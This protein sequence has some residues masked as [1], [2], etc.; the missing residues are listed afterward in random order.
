MREKRT[1]K[2]KKRKLSIWKDFEFI[3]SSTLKVIDAIL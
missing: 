3:S 2:T 1:K